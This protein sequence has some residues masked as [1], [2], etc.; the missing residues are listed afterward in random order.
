M[1]TEPTF[2]EFFS[3]T[4]ESAAESLT[5]ILKDKLFPEVIGF[6]KLNKSFDVDDAA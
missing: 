4:H 6:S 3:Q 1:T 5:K 2:G